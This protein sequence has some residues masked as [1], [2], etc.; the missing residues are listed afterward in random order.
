MSLVD[1]VYRGVV[2]MDFV[3]LGGFEA[4]S[5]ILQI[6]PNKICFLRFKFL[7]IH[8]FF[9]MIM[10]LKD[11]M[12]DTYSFAP[13]YWVSFFRDNASVLTGNR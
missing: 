10:P 3:P 2:A 13:Q 12:Q 7:T 6:H 1:Q 4:P 8:P 9:S 11:I 5:S